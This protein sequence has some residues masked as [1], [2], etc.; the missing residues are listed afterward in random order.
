[1]SDVG[2]GTDPLPARTQHRRVRTV[3]MEAPLP[4]RNVAHQSSSRGLDFLDRI[5]KSIDS[6][7]QALRDSN[8]TSTI[9][10]AQQTLLLQSQIRDLNQMVLSLCTQLD[11]SE[12]RRVGADRRADRL[13]NQIDIATAIT[14][15]RLF[16]STK[17]PTPSTSRQNPISISLSDSPSTPDHDRRWE[18]TFHDGGRCSWFGGVDRFP[19][20]EDVVEVTQIPWSPTPRSPPQ[21]PASDSEATS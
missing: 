14:C 3:R 8:R 9:F 1:M 10:Q 18:A 20:D 13:K 5:T 15:A 19:S 12:C 6:E 4:S 7:Q 21:S 17:V 16:W 11:D 2:K